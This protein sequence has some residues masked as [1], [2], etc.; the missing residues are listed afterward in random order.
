MDSQRIYMSMG[1]YIEKCIKALNLEPG[2]IVPVPISEAIDE[3]SKPLTETQVRTFL[4]ALGMVGW[5]AQTVRAD[6]AYAYSRIAQHS[7]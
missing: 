3:D 7:T 5:T 2:K 6:V 4:T 1:S